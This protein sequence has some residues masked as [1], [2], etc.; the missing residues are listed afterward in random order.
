MIA[1]H[2][3]VCH[4]TVIIVVIIRCALNKNKLQF[5]IRRSGF[6]YIVAT[7]VAAGLE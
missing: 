4:S 3:V 6:L 1:H 5:I 2:S 7:H